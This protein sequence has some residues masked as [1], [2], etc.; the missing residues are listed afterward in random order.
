MNRKELSNALELANKCLV[1]NKIIPIFGHLC[2]DK[3]NIQSFNG[4]QG[5]SVPFDSGLEFTVK[6]DL[7]TNLVDSFSSELIDL[8]KGT[9]IVTL[10]Q[11]KSSNKVMVQDNSTFISPFPKVRKGRK[12]SIDEKF[13]EGMKKCLVIADK[14]SIKESQNGVTIM[15]SPK[16]FFMYSTDGSRI[17]RYDIGSASPTVP[18]DTFSFLL[19]DK[20]CRLLVNLFSTGATT[21]EVDTGYAIATL[22]DCELFT[23]INTNVKLEN[24]DGAFS[25]Y[26]VDSLVY[27]TIP[28]LFRE[29]VTRGSIITKTSKRKKM[30]LTLDAT[31]IK[32]EV[33]SAQ[34]EIEEEIDLTNTFNAKFDVDIDLLA[35]FLS[36]V[37]NISFMKVDKGYI[38]AGSGDDFVA[39]LGTSV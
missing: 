4:V 20:F 31:K 28:D 17:A 18:V 36:V 24:F 6:G 14:S 15:S 26:K 21:L 8:Q 23:H 19:P 33:V 32:V 30:S 29:A 10:K 12:I 7:F 39:I 34:A 38:I 16:G 27:E 1:E 35:G 5:I 11:G 22:V 37:T 3:V 9:D 13:I 25:R 2:F